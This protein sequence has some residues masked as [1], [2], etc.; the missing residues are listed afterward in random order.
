M[1]QP[2]SKSTQPNPGPW[3]D[4]LLW[5]Y[6]RIFY[7]NGI[8]KNNK[9]LDTQDFNFRGGNPVGPSWTAEIVMRCCTFF[10]FPIILMRMLSKCGRSL[11]LRLTLV[12]LRWLLDDDAGWLV[13][14]HRVLHSTLTLIAHSPPLLNYDATQGTYLYDV[15]TGWGEGGPQKADKM[16]IISWF[17]YVTRGV[18]S[19]HRRSKACQYMYNLSRCTS[20]LIWLL[21]H[22]GNFQ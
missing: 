9:R 19:R 17:L 2:T 8:G 4:G 21:Q 16:T 1:E 6:W 13:A 7:G 22:G 12:N 3:G 18:D 15:C 14:T 20:E 11:A 10:S 5:M